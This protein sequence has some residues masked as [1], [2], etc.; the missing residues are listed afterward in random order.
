MFNIRGEGDDNH[1]NNN[2]SS[3]LG[4]S[5]MEEENHIDA[6]GTETNAQS[7]TSRSTNSPPSQG[8]L[9]VS[10][11]FIGNAKTRPH[12]LP[13]LIEELVGTLDGDYIATGMG[14]HSK[15]HQQQQ[16]HN[17]QQI[18]RR[19][20]K[21]NN[22]NQQERLEKVT[23]QGLENMNG[24]DS[25]AMVA[26]AAAAAV[27]SENEI[28]TSTSKRGQLRMK[29][30]NSEWEEALRWISSW[31]QTQTAQTS[32][33]LSK[34]AGVDEHPQEP[35]IISRKERRKRDSSRLP[36]NHSTERFNAD[37]EIDFELFLEVCINRCIGGSTNS[38]EGGNNSAIM[39]KRTANLNVKT[40][41]LGVTN[42]FVSSFMSMV[43]NLKV[44]SKQQWMSHI[45]KRRNREQMLRS[46][47]G[48]LLSTATVWL[49]R[50]VNDWRKANKYTNTL[51]SLLEEE[52]REAN[53]N[54]ILHDTKCRTH[55]STKK[56]KKA[57][58]K[59]RGRHHQKDRK[60]KTSTGAKT[61]NDNESEA[62]EEDFFERKFLEETILKH[63]DDH[64]GKECNTTVSTCTTDG[65]EFEYQM[66]STDA[67]ITKHK[68]TNRNLKKNKYQNQTIKKRNHGVDSKVSVSHHEQNHVGTRINIR[69]GQPSLFPSTSKYSS[70]KFQVKARDPKLKGGALGDYSMPMIPIP[71]AEQREESSRKLR[72][73]Q[74]I[75][76]QKLID[77]KKRLSA[78]GTRTPNKGMMFSAVVK[79]T[80]TIDL[81]KANSAQT[82]LPNRNNDANNNQVETIH[83]P[84]GLAKMT[85]IKGDGFNNGIN[86]I[87]ILESNPE[88][89]AGYLLSLL[90]EEEEENESR[91]KSTSK[92]TTPDRYHHNNI[93]SNEQVRSIALGDL[94]VGSY[95]AASASNHVHGNLN[96][97]SNPWTKDES[98]STVDTCISSPSH[99]SY[100]TRNNNNNN[101]SNTTSLSSLSNDLNCS[102]DANM[103]L[104]VSAVAFSPSVESIEPKIW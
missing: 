21:D 94:L 103:C 19:V 50:N 27:L 42:R 88:A 38:S 18:I 24:E 7:N 41:T 36:H 46:L 84:P 78:A 25:V 100:M 39:D 87:N 82:I 1:R 28:S 2:E 71:T 92:Q 48:V 20:K 13:P 60:Y 35:A 75:Q 11:N 58:R 5:S 53:G 86:S 56:S 45:H 47:F 91:S 64:T 83:H 3:Y 68:A 66:M 22:Y 33:S 43:H 73:Y 26:A 8:L 17:Q 98:V 49:V 62:S 51:R 34:G 102:N 79:E 4:E 23:K 52:R 61:A 37:N 40:T 30:V 55:G 12:R 72:E 81:A 44:K 63:S 65:A 104:Q 80:P 77:S 9:D 31:G 93:N 67:T 57:R 14:I 96:Y 54:P 85:Q 101:N 70:S 15:Q 32:Q 74:Q 95:S 10:E 76:I 16:G 59:N 6:T 99:S 29:T 97:S 69:Q 90:D 89:D